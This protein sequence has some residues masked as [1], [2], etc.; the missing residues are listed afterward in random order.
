[1]N[2]INNQTINVEIFLIDQKYIKLWN[3]KIIAN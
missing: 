2:E 1:M 3:K